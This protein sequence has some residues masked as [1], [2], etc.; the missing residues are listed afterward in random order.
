[1]Q[2]EDVKRVDFLEAFFISAHEV[3]LKVQLIAAAQ[4]VALATISR[5]RQ[6]TIIARSQVLCAISNPWGIIFPGT[7]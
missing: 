2:P 3:N 5:D 1:L 4:C 6:Q 7:Q